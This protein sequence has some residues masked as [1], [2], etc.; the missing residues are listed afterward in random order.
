MDWILGV[1]SLQP[2][3]PS[4]QSLSSERIDYSGTS[5]HGGDSGEAASDVNTYEES[6]FAPIPT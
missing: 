5:S 4:D 1:S 6:Y 2:R 3:S